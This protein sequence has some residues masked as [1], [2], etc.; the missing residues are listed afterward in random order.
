MNRNADLGDVQRWAIMGWIGY[1]ADS[2]DRASRIVT[3]N[4]LREIFLPD[5]G[6]EEQ[7]DPTPGGWIRSIAVD[8]TQE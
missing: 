5:L 3:M 8:S 7:R 4:V 2:G 6:S 1:S